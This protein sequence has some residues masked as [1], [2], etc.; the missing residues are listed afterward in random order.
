M[1]DIATPPTP[2]P[3]RVLL[4]LEGAQ[5]W[6][7]V[8]GY[9]LHEAILAACI[10]LSADIGGDGVKVCAVMPD[11]EAFVKMSRGEFP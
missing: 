7:A 11:F 3:Y 1:P 5:Q 6:V 4:E 2:R 8:W 9:D 10:K